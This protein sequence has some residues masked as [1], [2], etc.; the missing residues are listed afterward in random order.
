MEEK[1]GTLWKK[2]EHIRQLL[3]SYFSSILLLFFAAFM[4]FVVCIMRTG[5]HAG[6]IHLNTSCLLRESFPISDYTDV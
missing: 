1:R 6:E 4:A 5:S 3:S 2:E